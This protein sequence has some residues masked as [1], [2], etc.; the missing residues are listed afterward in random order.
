MGDDV[1]CMG[2]KRLKKGRGRLLESGLYMLGGVSL[3][4]WL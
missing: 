4:V 3:C 2:S 1:F